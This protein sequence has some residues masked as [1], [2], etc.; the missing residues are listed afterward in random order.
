MKK[1]F[2]MRFWKYAA[3]VLAGGLWCVGLVGQFESAEL[4]AG[5][6]AVSAAM[7]AI[8]VV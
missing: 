2:P 6:M 7:V 3:L 1:G 4:V 5:Y 8:A